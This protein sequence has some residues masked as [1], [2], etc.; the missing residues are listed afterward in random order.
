MS[1]VE[2]YKIAKKMEIYSS[3]LGQSVIDIVKVL[4]Q[5]RASFSK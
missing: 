3:E 2:V 1:D 5:E 4:P